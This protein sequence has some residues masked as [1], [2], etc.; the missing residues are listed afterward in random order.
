MPHNAPRPT[1]NA[2]SRA[3]YA[4]GGWSIPKLAREY[5]ISNAR[6]HQILK[7]RSK[8]SEHGY[9]LRIQSQIDE[10]RSRSGSLRLVLF[11]PRAAKDQALGLAWLD[12]LSALLNSP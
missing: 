8:E 10:D 4:E 12:Y 1:R 9:D 7:Q 5:G 6:D 3:R 2:E 11:P